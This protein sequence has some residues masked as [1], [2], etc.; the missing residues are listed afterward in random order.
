MS[1]N[2]NENEKY[3]SVNKITQKSPHRNTNLSGQILCTWCMI[4][5]HQWPGFCTCPGGQLAAHCSRDASVQNLET[6][7]WH[8]I[9]RA[10]PLQLGLDPQLWSVHNLPCVTMSR[11]LLKNPLM[12]TECEDTRLFKVEK[13]E[14]R[15]RQK[16][17]TG[18]WKN[19]FVYWTKLAIHQKYSWNHC[20][21]KIMEIFL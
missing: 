2:G 3:F 16:I 5:S 17:G 13:T 10:T 12:I 19:L 11:H 6:L 8:H 15:T 21:F 4:Q 9:L 7:L 20:N 14:E 18:Q 1:K